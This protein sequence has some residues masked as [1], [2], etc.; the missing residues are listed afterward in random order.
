MDTAEHV[1]EI[2][3]QGY[4]VFERVYDEAWVDAVRGEI[5][6]HYEALG[7]PTP[8]SQDSRE[9]AE[10]VVVC[11]AGL[12]V[13]SLLRALPHRAH[14]LLNPRAV[15]CMRRVLGPQMYMEVAGWIVSDHHRPFFDW[16]VHIHGQD[17]SYHLERGCWPRLSSVRRLMTLLYLEDL[18]GDHGTF[19][20]YPRKEGDPAEPPFEREA[21]AWPGQVE[22]ALPRGS[23]LVV[24]QSTWHAV[25]RQLDDELRIWIGCTFAS[26]TAHRANWF[27]PS[28]LEY[29]TDDPLLGSVLPQPALTASAS[30]RRDAADR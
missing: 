1:R 18:G 5:V 17:D 11:M 25:R 30:P 22:L 2:R 20:V 12:S 16:H 14:G 9:V 24:D 27:D 28:L 10:D 19:L 4:T 3:E 15:E 8:W 6:A 7:A 26:P 13:R 29:T 23:L 21:H